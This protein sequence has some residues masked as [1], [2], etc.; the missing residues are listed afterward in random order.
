M[1]SRTESFPD[2][3]ADSTLRHRFVQ[4]EVCR[5]PDHLVSCLYLGTRP[6]KLILK[7]LRQVIFKITGRGGE[8]CHGA[9][10]SLML[11]SRTRLC[12]LSQSKL[13]ITIRCDGIA[14]LTVSR[15]AA[16]IAHD[17]RLLLSLDVAVHTRHP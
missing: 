8:G 11:R 3:K 7:I 17:A 6:R 16:T 15:M 14:V 13:S 10:K 1:A 4:R 2:G 12:C 5:P 9:L